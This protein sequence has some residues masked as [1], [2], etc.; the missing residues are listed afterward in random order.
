MALTDKLTAIANALRSKTGGT[1]QM[2]LDEIAAGIR[3]LSVGTGG[4][5]PDTIVAGD[6]PVMICTTGKSITSTTLADTGLTLTMP[7]AGTYRFLVATSVAGSA[8]E[9]N[10]FKNG[11][12]IGSQT[13]PTTPTAPMSFDLECARG[14]VITVKGCRGSGYLAYF[15]ALALIACIDWDNGF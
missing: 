14:D 11:T 8:G 2:T 12:G 1:G 15:S 13:A 9:V 10:L 7:K 6:T 3:G 5:L 4:G